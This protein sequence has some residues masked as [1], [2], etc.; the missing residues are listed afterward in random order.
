M[1]QSHAR[2]L[3][4]QQ[5]AGGA[6]PI[7]RKRT[8]IPKSLK[9]MATSD[10]L[11]VVDGPDDLSVFLPSKLIDYLGAQVPILGIVPPGAAAKLLARLDA[12]V[13]RSAQS[14]TDCIG[15]SARCLVKRQIDDRQQI[16]FR[17]ERIQ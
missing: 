9:L 10:L 4:A 3:V 17:G 14:R 12:P 13:S 16:G 1:P 11:L 8:H 6:G 15:A 5:S 7:V 2:T